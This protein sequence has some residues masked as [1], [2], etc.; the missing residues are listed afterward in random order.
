[1]HQVFR[2]KYNSLWLWTSV[3]PNAKLSSLCLQFAYFD[4][5]FLNNFCFKIGVLEPKMQVGLISI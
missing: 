3:I 1:M 2:F 4:F 5:Y